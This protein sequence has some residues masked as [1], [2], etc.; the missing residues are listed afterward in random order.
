M[1][2]SSCKRVLLLSCGL[3]SPPV[4]RMYLEVLLGCMTFRRDLKGDVLGFEKL[5][6]FPY[7]RRNL[8]RI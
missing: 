1:S 2:D 8:V 3:S 5:L 6:V 7:S 4:L